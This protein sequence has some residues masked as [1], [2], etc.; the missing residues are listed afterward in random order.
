M[1]S[2]LSSVT[3]QWS[4]AVD[5]PCSHSPSVPTTPIT[6]PM[7]VPINPPVNPST[8]PSIGTI[9]LGAVSAVAIAAAVRGLT[10]WI[11]QTEADLRKGIFTPDLDWIKTVALPW[12]EKLKAYHTYTA[13]GLENIPEKGPALIVFTHSWATYDTALLAT[14]ILKT[15]GRLL[16]PLTDRFMF[17]TP[18]LN[19]LAKKT[20]WSLA[21]QECAKKLLQEGELVAVAPGGMKEALRPSS[22][23]YTVSWEHRQGFIK[24]AMEMGVPIILAACPAA[25]DIFTLYDNPVTRTAYK[26]FKMPIPLFRGRWGLPIPRP[27]ALNHAIGTPIQLPHI[28]R[29]QQSDILLSKWHRKISHAM[30]NLIISALA[31]RIETSQ[32]KP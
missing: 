32:S 14:E 2:T 7:Q 30:E 19:Q 11:R 5:T 6:D 16:R 26:Q 12:A 8:I 17:R 3:N 28:S 4:H 25:D 15:R 10:A 23:A 31:D 22:N 24:L 9:A 13:T 1:I 29:D 20:G 18:G 21:D 27:I